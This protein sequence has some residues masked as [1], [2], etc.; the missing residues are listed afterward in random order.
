MDQGCSRPTFGGLLLFR[1]VRETWVK[2]KNWLHEHA[3]LLL[4]GLQLPIHIGFV[5]IPLFVGLDMRFQL[6]L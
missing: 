6:F 2:V 5:P 4:K 3:L 1:H